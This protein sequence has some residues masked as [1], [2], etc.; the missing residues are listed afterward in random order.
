MDGCW[1]WRG[2][3]QTCHLW[4]DCTNEIRTCLNC[5]VGRKFAI[6]F[7]STDP[8]LCLPLHVAYAGHTVLNLFFPYRF[9]RL[10]KALAPFLEDLSDSERAAAESAGR[11]S[12]IDTFQLYSTDGFDKYAPFTPAPEGGPGE[13]TRSAVG[14]HGA[15]VH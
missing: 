6:V 11:K 3:H 4:D 7:A 10:D 2:I 15:T 5:T 9:A 13:L 14:S 1:H 8:L 12:G